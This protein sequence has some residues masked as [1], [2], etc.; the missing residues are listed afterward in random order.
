MKYQ[1]FFPYTIDFGT[2]QKTQTL[3]HGISPELSVLAHK[4]R[5]VDEAQ[6][7]IETS[8]PTGYISKGLLHTKISKLDKY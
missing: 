7:K 8:S 6:N 1:D 2:H 5:E 3:L 4:N